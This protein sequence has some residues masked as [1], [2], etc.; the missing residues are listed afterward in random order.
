MS[1]RPFVSTIIPNYNH[2]NYLVR[3]LESVFNQS[4]DN[5]EVII[6]DDC[7]VDNSLEIIRRYSN[8]PHLSSI[9]VNEFNTGSPFIQ[10]KKG[11]QLAKGDLIWIA[12][13]DDYCE[14][15]FLEEMVNAFL[16]NE[17][18]SV[19][20][21]SYVV[22]NDEGYLSRGKERS[23]I[24]FDGTSFVRGWM[25]IENAIMNASGAVFKKELFTSVSGDYLTFRAAGDYQFWTE[26]ASKG[27]VAYVRKNLSYFRVGSNSVTSNSIESGNGLI[28]DLRICYYILSH[29]RL[30][31]FQKEAMSASFSNKYRCRTVLSAET[32]NRMNSL[33]RFDRRCVFFDSLY[34][35]FISFIRRHL[36]LLI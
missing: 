5:F 22:F 31:W 23:T 36:G 24:S 7:S 34:L 6:L 19:A 12:E 28:E 21:S 30:S 13:S 10:W 25:S 29:F 1:I 35:R 27:D 17:K 16:L 2:A 26:I 4:Y 33:W 20:F 8:N 32:L 9:I 11:I 18:L 15:T 3:R 14:L